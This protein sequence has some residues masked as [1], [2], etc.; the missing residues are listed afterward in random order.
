MVED[1][2]LNKTKEL[3]PRQL[4]SALHNPLLQGDEVTVLLGSRQAG[5]TSILFRLIDFLIKQQKVRKSQIEYL[6]LEFPQLLSTIN[7]LYGKDFLD[8]LASRGMDTD[9]KCYVFIDEIHYLENPA[10]FLK[11]IHDHFSQINLTVSGSSSLQIQNKFK[12]ALTGR[13]NIFHVYPL[14]FS[15]Y[16][17]FKHSDL[18]EQKKDISIKNI[19]LKGDLPDLSTIR[20]VQDTF[21]KVFEEFTVYGG[22]PRPVL[23]PDVKE[24]IRHLSEIYQSYVMKDIKDFA[25]IQ[26]I[27]AFN[28]MIAMLGHQTGSLI[29]ISELCT[30]LGISRPAV[31]HYLFLLENTFIITLLKP[32]FT[33]RRKEIVKSPKVYF[34]DTGLR[35]TAVRNFDPMDQRGDSGSLFENAVYI[36]L[37]KKLDSMESLH[38]YRTKTKSEVDFVLK[39]KGVIPIEVKYSTFK[40]PRIPSGLRSF[41]KT[42]SPEYSFVICKDMWAK[43]T[44]NSTE[45]FFIPGWAV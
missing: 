21:E 27:N 14:S 28:N 3:F 34:D 20:F 30:S 2:I 24:R 44:L 13:K 5:K 22:Y 26:N 15:E 31:E 19:L 42:Y 9:K 11:T 17:T 18:A 40:E 38:Y 23:I 6:D 10:S 7:G 45:I 35:N 43:Q 41:I 37:H 16:L 29:N 33:N 36:Q 25:E 8:F 12:D 1:Y 39:E 4:E 32:Y